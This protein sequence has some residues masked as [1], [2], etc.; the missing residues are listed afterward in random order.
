MPEISTIADIARIQARV[1]PDA[2]A[3]VGCLVGK[4]HAV[5]KQ[6]IVGCDIIIG[7][8]TNDLTIVVAVV[9]KTI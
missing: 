4:R 7:E 8:G 1:R 6:P 9:W 3:L 2:T 5:C